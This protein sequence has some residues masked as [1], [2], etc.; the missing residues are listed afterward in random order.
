MIG[1]LALNSVIAF[2]YYLRL[3]WL[4]WMGDAP[5]GVPAVQPSVQLAGVVVV[6][7]LGTVVLGVLPGLIS[8]ATSQAVLATP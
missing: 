8:T 5:A 4:M 7:V 1:F 3:V 6:L 2:F